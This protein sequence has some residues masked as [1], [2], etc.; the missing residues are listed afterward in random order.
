MRSKVF[1]LIDYI[2]RED[3]KSRLVDEETAKKDGFNSSDF[4]AAMSLGLIKWSGSDY[5]LT[6]KGYNELLPHRISAGTLALKDAIEDFSEKSGKISK[7]MLDHTQSL[8]FYTILLVVLT[9][10]LILIT[11]TVFFR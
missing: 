6:E 2:D 10:I 8:R 1:K 3:A 11:I 9:I 4:T 5:R 7:E